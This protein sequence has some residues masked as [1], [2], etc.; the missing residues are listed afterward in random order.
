MKFFLKKC[1]NC[2]ISSV[3]PWWPSKAV[4]PFSWELTVGNSRK[5]VTL[6]TGVTEGEVAWSTVY[7]V[8]KRI[9]T[10]D[11]AECASTDL[12]ITEGKFKNFNSCV[13]LLMPL[14]KKLPES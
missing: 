10:S 8:V 6:L 12:C 3:L 1:K 13:I 4:R 7:S 5:V 9:C 11:K 14:E 2:I